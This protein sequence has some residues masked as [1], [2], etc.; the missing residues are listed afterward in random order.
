[1]KPKLYPRNLKDALSGSW[2]AV[3]GTGNGPGAILSKALAAGMPLFESGALSVQCAFR[4]RNDVHAFSLGGPG[5]TGG[6]PARA[7]RVNF[8]IRGLVAR[9]PSGRHVAHI[10]SGDMSP[11]SKAPAIGA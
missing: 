9:V 1:M 10:Q 2:A 4:V 6:V 11:H 3:A 7:G 8:G 5:R